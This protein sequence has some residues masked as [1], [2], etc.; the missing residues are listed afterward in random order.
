VERDILHFQA[1][2][3]TVKLVYMLAQKYNVSI[4]EMLRN[5]VRFALK[6]NTS[7]DDEMKALLEKITTEQKI[8]EMTEQR[9]LLQRKAYL[10]ANYRSQIYRMVEKGVVPE[11]IEKNAQSYIDEIEFSYG[12]NSG[13]HKKAILWF[14]R[15]EFGSKEKP[16]MGITG[17]STIPKNES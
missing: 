8:K 14:K 13:E 2:Q 10:P 15:R 3:H 11:E 5:M 12:K 4:S 1:D 9:R 6:E 17:E 16:G 7:L